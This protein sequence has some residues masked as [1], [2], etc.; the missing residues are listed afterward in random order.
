MNRLQ[1][2]VPGSAGRWQASRDGFSASLALD[3]IVLP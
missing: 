1:D 2:P 3:L